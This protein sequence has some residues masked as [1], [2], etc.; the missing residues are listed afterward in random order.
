MG[1]LRIAV[2]VLIFY[3]AAV[4]IVVAFQMAAAVDRRF[5]WPLT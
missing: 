3:I 2:G 1:A 5:A 4:F